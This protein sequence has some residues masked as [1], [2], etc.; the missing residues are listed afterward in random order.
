MSKTGQSCGLPIDQ[1]RWCR[2]CVDAEGRLQDFETR[3]ER[4]VQ[5]SLR[6]NPGLARTEAERQTLDYMACMP[7]WAGHPRVLA[8]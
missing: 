7:S 8:R 5:W 2:H 3:F 4:M 1:G 6:E